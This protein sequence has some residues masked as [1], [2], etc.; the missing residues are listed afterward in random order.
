MLWP[1]APL[2]IG[3]AVTVYCFVPVSK[4]GGKMG[5]QALF[6]TLGMLWRELEPL[7]SAA[8]NRGVI[9][10]F[11]TAFWT[12]IARDLQRPPFG[13]G[14]ATAGAF[15]LVGVIAILAASFTGKLVNRLGAR[16]VITPTSA[17]VPRFVDLLWSM[18]CCCWTRHCGYPHRSCFKTSTIS[19]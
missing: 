4:R 3:A 11:A 5:Y 1:S 14:T 15:D 13:F 10:A 8:Y 18:E 19:K 2:A 6:A 9:F 16:R 12:I 7:R 17:V